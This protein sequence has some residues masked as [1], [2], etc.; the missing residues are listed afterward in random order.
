MIVVGGSFAWRSELKEM[1]KAAH[2]KQSG[3]IDALKDR[4]FT[5]RFAK[6]DEDGGSRA[7]SEKVKVS[8]STMCRI[9]QSLMTM[10]AVNRSRAGWTQVATF[11]NQ[12]SR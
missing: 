12:T 10:R 7:V 9:S 2:L 6:V 5:D 8:T 4:L 11:K 1:C 3:N